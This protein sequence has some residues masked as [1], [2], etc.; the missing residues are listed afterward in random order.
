MSAVVIT[1]AS[2][3]IGYATA[4]LLTLNGIK[5]FGSVRHTDDAS[6]LQ[7]ELGSGFT[8]LLFDITNEENV[9]QA[10]QS[11]R[12]QL[13]KP[14]LGLI[15]NAGIAVQGPLLMMRIAD[16]KRQLDINLTGQLIVTQT[17]TPL[18]YPHDELAGQPGK[19]IN[20]SSASGKIAYPFM[21]AYAVSKHGLEAFSEALRRELMI[22]GIDVIIVGPG[23]IKTPI[24]EKAK[25]EPFPNELTQSIYY[26][27]AIALKNYML[28]NAEKNGLP[29][30]DVANLILN[31]L[32]SSHPKTRYPIMSHKWMSWIL[33]NLLPKRL[34]DKVIA[35]KFGLTRM[36]QK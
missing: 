26:P 29:V 23:A 24:W 10:A 4:K 28:R 22:Y 27:A 2:T 7:K 19:I 15:N 3:G 18:L 30:E 20:I 25:N 35:K 5:V 16:F 9:K 13:D 33:P 31:I 8:P 11:V 6:R 32:N 14:L 12:R 17:F 36:K 21:G 34:F 1:G